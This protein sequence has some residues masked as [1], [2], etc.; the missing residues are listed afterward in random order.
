MPFFKIL[1]LQTRCALSLL[2]AENSYR[3]QHPVA[4]KKLNQHGVVGHR[5]DNPAAEARLP[6]WDVKTAL[7]SFL[8]HT[9]RWHLRARRSALVLKSS[10]QIIPCEK[11]GLPCP[12][13]PRDK[14]QIFYTAKYSKFLSLPVP[15]ELLKNF[16]VVIYPDIKW[17]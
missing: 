7:L 6:C 16:C 9:L 13:L 14:L 2:K 10:E 11:V 17:I 8:V 12:D 1:Q 3:L 15:F 4:P 5:E